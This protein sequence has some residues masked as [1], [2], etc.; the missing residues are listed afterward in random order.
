M[1][2]R[3]KQFKTRRR[4][5]G[6]LALSANSPIVKFGAVAVGYLMSD[7]INAQIDKVTGGKVDDKIVAG[8]QLVA[9]LFLFTGKGKKS[10]LKTVAGGILT[11][12][13]TKKALQSFG[14]LSGFADVPVI[15]GYEVP[16]PVP[17]LNGITDVPVIS[18]YNV[19]QPQVM[20]SVD[21]MTGEKDYLG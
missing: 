10:V 20:G 7:Q 1:A 18:G 4:R 13:G 19:P 9:G 16:Q 21:S 5:I 14:I 15:S 3:R 12:A 6:A 11:G 17:S 2:K 8:A